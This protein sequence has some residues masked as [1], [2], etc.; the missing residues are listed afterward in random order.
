MIARAV[1]LRQGE[2]GIEVLLVRTSSGKHWIFPGGHIKAGEPTGAGVLREL[3]EEAGFGGVILPE[4]RIAYVAERDTFLVPVL[5]AVQEKDEEPERERRWF[6]LAGALEALADSPWTAPLADL[7]LL[8]EAD[9]L[10]LTKKAWSFGL[11][12]VTNTP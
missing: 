8:Y 2:N 3:R 7:A 6:S 1:C 12:E 9:H 4:G 11:T 5:D 10:P